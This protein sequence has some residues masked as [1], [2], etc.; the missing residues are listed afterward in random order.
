V[1]VR[2]PLLLVLLLVLC[3]PSASAAEEPTAAVVV[4][5]ASHVE[6]AAR[7]AWYAP[8]I[9]GGTTPFGAGLGARVGYALSN[10]YFGATALGFF[11]GTDVDSSN[12]AALYGG[13]VGAH[14]FAHATPTAY[15]VFRPHVGLG[16]ATILHT[17]PTTT[18]STTTSPR[19][20]TTRNDSLVGSGTDVIT[21]ASTS[22]STRGGSGGSSSST[23]SVTTFYVEPGMSVLFSS[24]TPTGGAAFVGA[25]ASMLLLPSVAYG[26]ASS[27]STWLT[28]SLGADLG[29]F[30]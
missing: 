11:G 24:G 29:V 19:G 1:E 9:R 15:F 7:G 3:A 30:F 20:G 16:G 12:H 21:A 25:N 22:G 4:P 2:R 27:S 18:S 10:L 13:E 14:F 17:E 6:I 28:Y 26:G 23:T 8:P 5:S